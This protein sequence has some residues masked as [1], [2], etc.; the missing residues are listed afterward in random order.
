MPSIASPTLLRT[1]RELAEPLAEAQG[2]VLTAVE[3]LGGMGSGIVRI[4]IDRPGGVS[5]ENCTRVS[6][7]LSRLLDETDPI[8]SAYTLEVSSPGIQ[9]PVQRPEDFAYFAGCDIRVK[10]YG[11]DSRRAAR[12]RLVGFIDGKIHLLT[13]SGPLEI[14]PDDVERAWLALTD[15]QFA[16][17][18]QGLHPIAGGE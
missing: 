3:I 11:T 2:C 8:P 16:R 18:G 7:A 6:R 17:L 9:R 1:L 4:S 5:I 15:D 13:D 10:R 14:H 12:G